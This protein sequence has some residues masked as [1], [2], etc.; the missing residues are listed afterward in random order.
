[1]L[2]DDDNRKDILVNVQWPGG[3]SGDPNISTFCHRLSL[4]TGDSP[5]LILFKLASEHTGNQLL[6]RQAGQPAHCFLYL[7]N[8]SCVIP[9]LF[10]FRCSITLGE[11][12]S[13]GMQGALN[14]YCLCSLL[15]DQFKWKQLFSHKLLLL[16]LL[17]LTLLDE[18]RTVPV[19]N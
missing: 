10:I 3:H 5:L 4:Q 6:D 1:M 11:W 15:F 16:P 17:L 14:H 13:S 12:S 9:T 7:R 8:H 18:C 2:L 19:I